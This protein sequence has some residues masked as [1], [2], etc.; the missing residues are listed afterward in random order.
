MLRKFLLV[1]VPLLIVLQFFHPKKNEVENR[2]VELNNIVQNLKTDSE[3]F[4]LLEVACLDCHSNTTIYPWYS[5]ISPLN[6][7]LDKHI[8]H[9]KEH[10]NFSAWVTY[11][12]EE[13]EHLSREIIEVMEKNKM[14]L[15]SYKII[16]KDAIL[17]EKQRNAII[18]WVNNKL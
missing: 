8:R 9:G 11:G 18:S 7:W 4:N 12:R 17:D 10:L 15:K 13:K 5:K 14:P 3:V 16:H 1:I 6:F 2:E